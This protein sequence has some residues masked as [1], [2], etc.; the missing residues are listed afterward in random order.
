MASLVT[1]P[2]PRLRHHHSFLGSEGL[3]AVAEW[4]FLHL[5]PIYNGFDV[6]R[7]NG[8]PVI[9]IYG[10]AAPE[11]STNEISFWATRQGFNSFRSGIGLLNL[12]CLDESKDKLAKVIDQACNDT[13]EAVVLAGHSLGGALALATAKI[14]PPGMVRSVITFCSPMVP[15]FRVNPALRIAVEFNRFRLMLTPR[16]HPACFTP[17]C[18]CSFL[19]SIT[20]VGSKLSFRLVNIAACNDRVVHPDDTIH[21]NADRVE[22]ID[23]THTGVVWRPEILQILAEELPRGRRN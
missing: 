2:T 6:D 16:R 4:G 18:K 15:Q 17:A 9:D 22:Y 7:G 13:G 8:E 12:N 10:F 20:E 19:R 14:L 5:S 11:L 21:P 3:E 23:C 1:E